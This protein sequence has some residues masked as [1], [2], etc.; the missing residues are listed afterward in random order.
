M[1]KNIRS[2]LSFL[3]SVNESNSTYLIGLLWSLKCLPLC[4]I[5]D[6][7]IVKPSI[8]T[9]CYDYYI[10][11]VTPATYAKNT[12]VTKTTNW[13]HSLIS[14][15]LSCFYFSLLQIALQPSSLCPSFWST[16]IIISSIEIPE[17]K[18]FVFKVF[19][20]YC[21]EKLYWYTLYE[22]KCLAHPC[23]LYV[24]IF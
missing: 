8:N 13:L 24:T 14:G 19:G 17:L 5:R 21:P 16:S 2:G 18:G 15:Y 22:Q 6:E 4:L 12:K 7:N 10:I 11:N 23:T 9:S 3:I 20:R 1:A